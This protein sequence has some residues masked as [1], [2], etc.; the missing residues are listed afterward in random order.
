MYL[1]EI[2][3]K[4]I[5][6]GL[7]GK[8]I[9][10]ESM[11][12][13]FWEVEKDTKVPLHEHVNEQIMHILEGEFE[14]TLMGETEIYESGSI[15]VIPSNEPHSGVALTPCRIMDVFSPVREEYR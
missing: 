15:I 10:G 14:F 8:I 4:E 9:H 7:H 1:K 12:W 5:M 11:T 3:T 13:A 2:E 6:P